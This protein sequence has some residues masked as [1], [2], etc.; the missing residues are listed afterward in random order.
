M[1]KILFH[2]V[3]DSRT[4]FYGS[5]LIKTLQQEIAIILLKIIVISS[6][7]AASSLLLSM[8]F[9]VEIQYKTVLAV[10]LVRFSV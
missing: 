1:T 5:M 2:N 6:D 9:Q 3:H 7:F 10:D 8:Q 4:L